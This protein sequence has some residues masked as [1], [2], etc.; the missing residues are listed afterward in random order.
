VR[1]DSE[2][3][4]EG[5]WIVRLFGATGSG[6]AGGDITL[7]QGVNSVTIWFRFEGT[8]IPDCVV[9]L[10]SV[11]IEDLGVKRGSH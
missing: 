4:T 7:P 10:D 3:T 1:Y 9:G 11:I 2:T 6:S 8:N 5:N